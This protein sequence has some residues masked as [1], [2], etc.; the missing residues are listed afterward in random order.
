MH[1]KPQQVVLVQIYL[2]IFS[3]LKYMQRC[4]SGLRCNPGK[5]VYGKLYHEFESRSLRH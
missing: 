4:P 2:N 5:V 1:L 3:K